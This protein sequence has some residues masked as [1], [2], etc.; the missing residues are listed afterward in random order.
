MPNKWLNHKEIEIKKQKYKVSNWSDYNNSLKKRGD[1]KV[2]LSQ[3][4][5]NNWYFNER[6]YDGT[7]STKCY[8]DEAI[9]ACHEIRQVYKLPLR[10]TEGF[11]NSLF[12]LMKLK[13]RSPDYTT[14]SK[15]LKELEIKCPGYTK[16]SK[17]DSDISAIALDSTGLKRFGR[18]EWHVE[19][20]Y[21]WL[22]EP[23]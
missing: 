17:T 2:W 23:Q 16:Y 6:I 4:L 21:D 7:G 20:H 19:K 9:I 8:T 12:K 18:D 10:Q 5:I 14:L 11:I 1:I 15:R 22:W 13:I 3:D